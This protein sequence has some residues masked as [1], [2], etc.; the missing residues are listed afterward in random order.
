MQTN[1]VRYFLAL[2]KERRF[3]SAAK[4]CGVSQ[5]SLTKAIKRL[6]QI[7]GGLLF[8]RNSKKVELTE[9]GR[10]VKPH[11]EQLNQSALEAKRRAQ[12]AL[13]HPSMRRQPKALNL[14][15]FSRASR[16]RSSAEHKQKH[17]PNAARHKYERHSGSEHS[18]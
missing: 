9:L 18:G 10:V 4:R 8:H 5:P 14:S 2:C 7:L 6:E 1:Q 12:E 16:R 3:T 15:I 17:P 11:L 13:H